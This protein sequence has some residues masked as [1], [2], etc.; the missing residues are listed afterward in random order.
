MRETYFG[1]G[2]QQ[3]VLTKA[4]AT[5][6]SFKLGASIVEVIVVDVELGAGV[7]GSCGTEGD[8][9]EVFAQDPVEDAVTEGTV[10]LENLIADILHRKVR[11]GGRN[12]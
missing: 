10:V 1:G 12:G 9:D 4:W 11:E 6:H 3:C 8:V 5:H 2:G 7:D